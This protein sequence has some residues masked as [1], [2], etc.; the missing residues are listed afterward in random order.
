MVESTLKLFYFL[1]PVIF[2]GVSNMLYVKLP[3][4]RRWNAPIDRNCLAGDGK[5]LFGE[6]KTWQGFVGM[7][8]F[9]AFWMF[10]FTHMA[11]T[12]DWVYKFALVDY[13][14]WQHPLQAWLYGAILGFGYVLFELPNS[15]MKRR[16]D[17]PPGK[18]GYGWRGIVFYFVDQADSVLGCLLVMHFFFQPTWQEALGIF[19]L[20]TIIHYLI[21]LI[22]FA[23]GLKKQAG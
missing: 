5:R 2:G 3:L 4:V 21:N 10:I 23:V 19:I 20:G 8:T 15:Y 18:N 6:N 9:T 11:N 7:I 13:R 14:A 12:Y 16:I 1:L 22:L 17:I